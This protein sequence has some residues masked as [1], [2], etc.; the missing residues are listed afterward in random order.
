MIEPQSVPPL[1]SLEHVTRR[2]GGLVALDDVSIAVDEG[3]IAGLIGP[4]GAGK[5]TAFNVATRL[6]TPDSGGVHYD[7]KDLLRLKAHRIAGL[8]V[9]R[10]FQNVV[11]FPAMTVLQNVLVGTHSRRWYFAERKALRDAEEALDYLGLAHLAEHPAAGLPFG[12]LKRLELARALAGR[13]RLL[14]LD[15]PAGGLNHEEVEELGGLIRRIKAD[16]GLTVLLVE[17]HVNLVMSISDRV[18]VLNFGA[19]IAEGTPAEV[20]ANPAV[21]EAYLGTADAA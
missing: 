19:K 1:L 7:G 8:G 15:E 9:A 6:Y 11:L 21:V 16:Y 14:L 17:H 10:T 13:P 4:N 3:E 5:T 18:H 12:T 2:F 20:R